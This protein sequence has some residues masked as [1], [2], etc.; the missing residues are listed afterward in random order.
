MGIVKSGLQNTQFS[1][2]RGSPCPVLPCDEFPRRRHGRDLSGLRAVPLIK[3]AGRTLYRIAGEISPE[4][5]Q[6]LN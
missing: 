4:R 1:P 5:S 6:S 3:A 2:D